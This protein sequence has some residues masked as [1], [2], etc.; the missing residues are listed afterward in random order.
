MFARLLR[1]DLKTLRLCDDVL[2]KFTLDI[3]I[4]SIVFLHFVVADVRNI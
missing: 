4:G 3:G 2:Y 1:R